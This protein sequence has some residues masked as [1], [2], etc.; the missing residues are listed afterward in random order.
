MA[1]NSAALSHDK[2]VLKGCEVGEISNGAEMAATNRLELRDI[3]RYPDRYW[4]GP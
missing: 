3:E 1:Q 4:I 2:V